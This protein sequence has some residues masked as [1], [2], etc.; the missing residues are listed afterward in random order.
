MSDND[1]LPIGSIGAVPAYRDVPTYRMFFGNL[2]VWEGD[3][4]KAE[5]MSWKTG[6][7]VAANLTGPAELTYRGRDAQAFLSSLSI[8]NVREWPVGTSKHLVMPDEN[9]LIANHGLAIRDSEDSFR[10][11]ASL[12]WGVHRLGSAGMD[13]E[14]SVREI[15]IL[16]VAGP[17]SLQVLERTLGRDLR[18]LKFLGIRKV[19]IAGVEAELELSRIGMAG[20]LAYEVRGPFDAGPVVYDAVYRAGKDIGLKRLGWRT[21][22]V[23]H[24]EGGFPQANCTFLPSVLSDEAFMAA[25]GAGRSTTMSGSVD[26]TDLRARYRTPA[27]VN[28]DWMAKFDHDF[29]GRAAVEAEKASPRRKTVILRW[30][31]EDILDVFASH[32]RPG[33]EYKYIEFPCAPQQIAGGHADLVTKDDEQVGVASAAVYSYYYREM[34]SQC[35]IDI[36]QAHIGNKVVLHWGDHGGRIKEIRATVE[37]FPYLELPSNRDYDLSTVPSGLPAPAR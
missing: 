35:V 27:E 16:Q 29:L 34:L 20:T 8:N 12:P 10:Q 25:Y 9:G 4:W 24:T 6:A 32:F 19:E 17:A 13:V 15:F 37:R 14:T 33:E 21:Y 30:N 31:A 26:P 3:G 22:A 2:H 11:L 7:Y 36:D 1:V 28:W 5:S 23:N 18:D